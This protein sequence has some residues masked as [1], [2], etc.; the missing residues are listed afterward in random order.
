MKHNPTVR[1]RP[2]PSSRPLWVIV[3]VAMIVTAY[4]AKYGLLRLWPPPRWPTILFAGV[5]FAAIALL[6]VISAIEPAEDGHSK[7]N[8]DSGSHPEKHHHHGHKSGRS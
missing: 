1:R 3:V 6:L 7:A 2:P 4:A 5:V 8:R